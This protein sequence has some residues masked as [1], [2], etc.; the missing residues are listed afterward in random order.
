VF[1][2]SPALLLEFKPLQQS[3]TGSH[4]RMRDGTTLRYSITGQDGGPRIALI[5]S[6]AMDQA[7]WLPVVARLKDTAQLLTYDCRG[8][9]ASDKPAGPY[10]IDLFANDLSDLLDAA[11]W[12][13]SIVAGASMGGS[14][15]L[16]FAAKYSS[17]L[18]G[19]GLFD[20][21]AWYGPNAPSSWEERAAKANT[22]GLAG[23]VGFQK[24]RWFGDAFRE[25]NPGIVDAS[26]ATFLAND[27]GA[28][29]ATCRMLGNFDLRT[30]LEKIAIPTAIAVGEE[31]YATPPAM[32]TDLY[33]AIKHSTLTI[34]KSGR[35]L[36][37]LEK[38]DEIAAELAR[39]VERTTR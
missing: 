15:A 20:T 39:L 8:H 22:E 21:T 26:V 31:D 3:P 28:Y 13:R 24:T 1:K 35:H 2:A 38:P 33:T 19:L 6:L 37:P 34:I 25:A 4:A 18:A 23:L 10:S 30:S 9:G 11:G 5:H 16:G 36:T 32:A 29:A 17:R 27:V 7:F 12:P 14:V